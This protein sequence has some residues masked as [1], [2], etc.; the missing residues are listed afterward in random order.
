MAVKETAPTCRWAS[1]SHSSISFF[2][3]R[4]TSLVVHYV[5]YISTS[6]TLLTCMLTLHLCR[7]S[8]L[9]HLVCCLLTATCN[10]EHPPV[11]RELILAPFCSSISVISGWLL[12][13][14]ENQVYY[15]GFCRVETRKSL[16]SQGQYHILNVGSLT[17]CQA[18]HPLLEKSYL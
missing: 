17:A 18:P 12:K 9:T 3:S 15:T 6:K 13:T 11:L 5:F 8:T 4:S 14:W 10:V 7:S 1:Q 2:H 16:P